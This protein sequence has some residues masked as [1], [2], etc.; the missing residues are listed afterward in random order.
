MPVNDKTKE[1]VEICLKS[2]DKPISKSF[3]QEQT[4]VD[5]DSLNVII[6]GLLKE[7][8]IRI[9]ET[10]NGIFYELIR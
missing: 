2:V 8:K 1:K 5:W 10:S 3:M 9:V 7:N 4:Q 6:E